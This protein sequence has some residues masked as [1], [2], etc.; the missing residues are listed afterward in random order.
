MEEQGG[1]AM[2]T[3]KKDEGSL[4]KDA[5]VVV[6]EVKVAAEDVLK[7]V[8][9]AIR[10]GNVRRITVKDKDGKVVASFPLAVGVIGVVLAPV[11][12]AIGALSAILTDCTLSIEKNA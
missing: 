11:L 4:Q 5:K 6:Q 8:K 3:E 10:E 2:A 9:E 1:V 12:A 7:I